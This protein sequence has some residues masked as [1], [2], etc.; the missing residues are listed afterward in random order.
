LLK[1][2]APRART[3]GT[4]DNYQKRSPLRSWPAVLGLG[5][6]LGPV[7]LGPAPAADAALAP[8]TC[9]L[10]PPGVVGP[11]Y[12]ARFGAPTAKTQGLVTV[13]SYLS[14]EPVISVLVRFETDESK[15][16][17][18]AGRRQFDRLGEHT[19][20]RAGFGQS[21]YSVTLGSGQ[22]LTGTLVVLTG[23]TELL[24]S[25]TG[26]LKKAEAL[27]DKVLPKL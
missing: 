9:A 11:I 16:E 5:V 24:V 8:P 4:K 25:G 3:V 20:T 27:A 14:V 18:E 22:V 1:T 19:V 23:P 26:P 13:C 15:A 7:A 2:I 6:A 12:G 10:A 17:F 21:A